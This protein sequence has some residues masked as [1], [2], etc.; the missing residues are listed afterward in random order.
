MLLMSCGEEQKSAELKEAF[1][2]HN[3]AVKVRQIADE[4]LAELSANTDSVF[5]ATHTKSLEALR[6]SLE[7]W[8]DQLVE[9]PGFEDEHDHSHHDHSGHD[10][11]HDHDH[12]HHGDQELTP[13]Q[14]L[15][16]QQQLL[17][18]I[19]AIAKQMENIK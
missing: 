9:V 6:Q 14:H 8:D 3:E 7:A 19:Q 16:V 18:E 2:L 12:D 17:K 13:Q 4:K 15:E 11:D 1:A 10:H 5:V